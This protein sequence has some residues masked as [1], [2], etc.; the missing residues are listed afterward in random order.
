[1]RRSYINNMICTLVLLFINTLSAQEKPIPKSNTIEALYPTVTSGA[2]TFAKAVKL[3]KDI[4]LQADGIEISIA[5][6]N[7][8]IASQPE[9]LQD[10]LKKNNLFVL[11]HLATPRLL[12]LIA[13]KALPE[14]AENIDPRNN[15]QLIQDYFDKNVFTKIGVTDSE[16]EQFYAEN[17]NMFGGAALAQVSEQIKPYLLGQKK[18]KAVAECL[19][20]IGKKIDTRVSDVWLKQQVALALDNPVDKARGS[21]KP[22]LVDFGAT[23]CVPCDMLAPILEELKGKYDGKVNVIFVHVREKQI[24]AAR[25]GIESIPVQ[26][27]FDAD[28][29]EIFR[30]VGFFPKEEIEKKLS[31]MGIK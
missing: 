7:K 14:V 19:R 9:A 22:S 1:M 17:K 18:Q 29:K 28:G 10:E 20:T 11:E 25:Y 26:V 12:F 23:G 27:F 3:S 16:I 15:Q 13:E 31:E 21:G 30:H 24:L 6:V 2:L 4:I 5:D 8:F